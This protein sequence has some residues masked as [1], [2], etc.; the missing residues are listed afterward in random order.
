MPHFISPAGWPRLHGDR[1]TSRW[2]AMEKGD[3]LQTSSLQNEVE[4]SLNSDSPLTSLARKGSHGT[5]ICKGVRGHQNIALCINVRIFS[6]RT[7]HLQ[8]KS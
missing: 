5:P 2:K 7:L 1:S 3:I 6:T 4:D 8:Q